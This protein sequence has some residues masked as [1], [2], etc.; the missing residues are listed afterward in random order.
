MTIEEFNKTQWGANMK[1]AYRGAN[2][3]VCSVNFFEALIG[4]CAD[5]DDELSWVRCENIELLD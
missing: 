3:E 5:H 1:F 4:Y 2:Y